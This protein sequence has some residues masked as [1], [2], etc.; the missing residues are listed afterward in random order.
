MLRIGL[1]GIGFM[2]Y[3]HFTAAARLKGAKLTALCSSSA[4]KL[5]G[6]WRGIRGNF[7]P[8]A[9]HVDT[10][11][12]TR[13]TEFDA[14]IADPSI[15]LVDICSPPDLHEEM[16][17][18]A[19]RAGKHVL[20][21]KPI[22]LE[23]AAADRMVA[24]ARKAG[25]FLMVG[26]VLPFFP[27]FRYLYETVQSGKYGRLRA[28]HFR[29]IIARPDWSGDMAS[30]AKTGGPAVDLHIHDTHFISLICG[31]PK[32]V[33]SRGIIENGFAQYLTTQ[34]VFEDPALSVSCS[35]G[36]IAAKAL[37]F[38]H[39][40]EAYFENATIQYEAGTLAKNWVVSRPLTVLT[41]DGKRSEPKLKAGSEWCSAFTGELQTAV[42][43]IVSGK[44]ARLLS[45]ELA[46]DALKLTQLE[47]RSAATGK[48]VVV[49]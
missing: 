34:Y 14:L 38:T 23:T 9:G 8:P 35:S 7:G 26:Q 30:D 47:T 31:V 10:S 13:Y 41:N 42:D 3:T 43:A 20:V 19:L 33:Q 37:E 4:K 45:G 40:F 28:A 6:D 21:E 27:E 11:K 12:L 49:K 44:E 18:K 17:V 1:A 48:T 2:G 16:A 29:R 32:A 36:G 46:R 22:A 24:A 25:K 15:D 39:G 5:A